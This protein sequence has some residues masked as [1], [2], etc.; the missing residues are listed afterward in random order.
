MGTDQV[1]VLYWCLEC[2]NFHWS[3][4]VQD[5]H[6]RKLCIGSKYSFALHIQLYIWLK[7]LNMASSLNKLE[8]MDQSKRIGNL[9]SKFPLKNKYAQYIHTLFIIYQ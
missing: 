4:W 5:A 7:Y 9:F 8:W 3:M 1:Q 2:M 6:V